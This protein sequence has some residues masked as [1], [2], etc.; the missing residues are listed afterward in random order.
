MVR[1][2]I[3]LTEHE[4]ATLQAM[5]SQRGSTQSELIREAI[6]RYIV[7]SGKTERIQMLRTGRGI[8]SDRGADEFVQIR[9]ELDRDF[10]RSDSPGKI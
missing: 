6:D 1:T 3:Y 4:R 5:A 10:D 7:A 2:Q 8:W 9:A